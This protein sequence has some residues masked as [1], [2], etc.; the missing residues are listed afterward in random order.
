MWV[1]RPWV[2]RTFRDRYGSMTQSKRQSAITPLRIG[3]GVASL[4]IVLV[5]AMLSFCVSAG[6]VW[7]DRRRQRNTGDNGLLPVLPMDKHFRCITAL[8]AGMILVKTDFLMTYA[9][10]RAFGGQTVMQVMSIA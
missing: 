3:S 6:S 10:T 1:Y 8:K 7:S 5:L 2:A 4:R 9:D